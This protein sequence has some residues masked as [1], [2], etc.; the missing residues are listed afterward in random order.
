M[1]LGGYRGSATLARI[2]HE[3]YQTVSSTDV[4]NGIF[5]YCCR[6][7]T[8]NANRHT[9]TGRRQLDTKRCLRWSTPK[10]R[11]TRLQLINVHA[12]FTL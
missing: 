9:F 8:V 6:Y 2:M 4:T 1:L 12:I 3:N 7:K 5:I 10:S 11:N